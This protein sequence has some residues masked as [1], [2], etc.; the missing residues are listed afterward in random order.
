M[1]KR[2]KPESSATVALMNGHGPNATRVVVGICVTLGKAT[3]KNFFQWSE[4]DQRLV[5]SNG[6]GR[7]R[8]AAPYS[9]AFI[10]SMGSCVI[11]V[12]SFRNLYPKKFDY[13]FS[14]LESRNF[15]EDAKLG[16]LLCCFSSGCSR[17]RVLAQRVQG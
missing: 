15:T 2:K 1:T 12:E 3:R 7:K 10:G 6:A 11:G 5:L 9:K 13:T 8:K 4:E 14:K 16:F 17:N